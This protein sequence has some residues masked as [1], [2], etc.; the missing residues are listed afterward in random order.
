M[1]CSAGVSMSVVRLARAVAATSFGIFLF[2]VCTG[3]GET[4]RPVAFPIPPSP[5]NPGASNSVFVL[6]SDGTEEA[7]VMSRIDVSGD[8]YLNAANLGIAPVHAALVPGGATLYT[9]NNLANTISAN[10]VSNSGTGTTISLPSGSA[11]VFVATTESSN[12]YAANYGLGTVSQINTTTNVVSTT[13]SVDPALPNN[14]DYTAAAPDTTSQ[15]VALAETPD[16][17]R[18]YAANRGGGYLTSINTVDDSRNPRISIGGTPAEVAARADSA[19]V[20]ALDSTTGNVYSI[21]P[22]VVPEPAPKSVPTAAGADFMSYDSGLNRLYVLKSGYVSA[23][24]NSSGNALWVLDASGSPALNPPALLA[25]PISIPAYAGSACG[26][27]T[28]VPVSVAAL[29]D[30]SRVY[31]ASYQI[32]GSTLC[33]QVNVFSTSGYVPTTV[34]STGATI[35]DTTDAT[36]CAL[37]RPAIPGANGPAGFR[38][39]IAA[40]ADLPTTRVYVANCDAGGTTIITTVPISAVGSQLAQSADTVLTSL[41]APESSFAAAGGAALPPPQNPLFVLS[42]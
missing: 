4:Y 28:P 39:S 41:A 23:T 7:G 20:F 6:S 40:A 42:Q 37:A 12:M 16:G 32:S 34:I 27:G 29:P 8:S 33:S 5:P 11:P 15:P 38:L 24:A 19:A 14:P 18:L 2:I 30:S 13:I 21:D 10:G 36:G 22:T 35:I 17:K 3:C 25:G 9:V 1:D 31:V 26:P